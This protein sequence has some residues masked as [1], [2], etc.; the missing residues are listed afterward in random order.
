MSK[1]LIID[2]NVEFQTMISCYFT[3]LGYTVELANN[4]REGLTKAKTIKPDIILLD[5]MMPD[6][7]GIEVLREL[8][9]DDETRIIPVIVITGTYFDGNMK[10]LFRQESNCRE[11]LSKTADLS[12]IQAKVAPLLKK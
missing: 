9:T 3:D 5:V 8:Q 10:E 1:M 11:F 4:G 2:D 12:L 6:T 7:G